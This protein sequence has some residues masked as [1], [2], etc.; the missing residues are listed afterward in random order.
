M[1]ACRNGGRRTIQQGWVHRRAAKT[2]DA[3]PD[4]TEHE[5][6]LMTDV[7]EVALIASIPPTLLALGT[8]IVGLR[9][10]SKAN[11][12]I[13]K[14]DGNYSDLKEELVTANERSAVLTQQI[15]ELVKAAGK[16]R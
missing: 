15:L 11:G 7:V 14:V 1:R 12:I 13:Q 5:D 8:F 16:R 2:D 10:G 6:L 9:N 3:Q 4:G